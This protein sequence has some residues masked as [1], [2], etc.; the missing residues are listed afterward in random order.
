MVYLSGR[1]L[2]AGTITM[3][4]L[5]SFWISAHPLKPN[6]SIVL[7][8]ACFNA[9]VHR[10]IIKGICGGPRCGAYSVVLSGEYADK[11]EG[12]TLCVVLPLMLDSYVP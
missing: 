10:D 8:Q 12:D 11:D 7:S 5:S 3:A 6:C 9:G 2:Q 1:P 4:T